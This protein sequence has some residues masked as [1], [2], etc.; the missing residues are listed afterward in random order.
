MPADHD[1]QRALRIHARIFGAAAAL[2][3]A[4]NMALA[5]ETWLI[6]PVLVWGFVLFLHYLYVKSRTVDNRWAS[7]RARD[8]AGHAYDAGH[9]EDIRDRYRDPPPNANS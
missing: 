3:V 9:I 2:F 8:V 4:G 7:Q 1:P 5:A 6:W